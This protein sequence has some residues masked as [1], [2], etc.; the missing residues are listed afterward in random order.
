MNGNCCFLITLR[1]KEVNNELILLI[2]MKPVNWNQAQQKDFCQGLLSFCKPLYLSFLVTLKILKGYLSVF[3]TDCSSLLRDMNIV[4]FFFFLIKSTNY[5]SKNL[6][7]KILQ[8]NQGI[9]FFNLMWISMFRFF[10]MLCISSIIIIHE[11]F[12]QIVCITTVAE[13]FVSSLW[14]KWH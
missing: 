8:I 2:K 11:S 6:Q 14:R 9:F 5:F 12:S 3:W 7:M 10:C 4:L 1:R 13:G